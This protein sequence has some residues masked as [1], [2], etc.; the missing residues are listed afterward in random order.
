M[1]KRNVRLAAYQ[2]ARN[3]KRLVF[4]RN[5]RCQRMNGTY[6]MSVCRSGRKRQDGPHSCGKLHKLRSACGSMF[7]VLSP[8]L[9][10]PRKLVAFPFS[11]F[12][13]VLSFFFSPKTLDASCRWGES[14]THMNAERC[15]PPPIAEARMMFL[16]AIGSTTE[17]I[18]GIWQHTPPC[19]DAVLSPY[20]PAS[21][22]VTFGAVCEDCDD[23]LIRQRLTC[24][25][26]IPDVDRLEGD[27]FELRSVS[28]SEA[29]HFALQLEE[30]KKFVKER[31]RT[32]SDVS[33][34]LTSFTVDTPTSTVAPRLSIIKA[35]GPHTP[36]VDG[37][38]HG[39]EVTQQSDTA[40]CGDRVCTS[41]PM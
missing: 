18:A 8:V 5:W 14:H 16:S 28:S 29:L 34:G 19:T 38:K 21:H 35:S 2:R 39:L 27:P 9:A 3:A 6:I 7:N 4:S 1:V 12:R 31:L 41:S 40:L 36:Q 23:D 30:T 10:F 22:I 13:F 11:R 20:E 15:S 25:L 32:D 33:S 37:D 17:E 24:P 26:P